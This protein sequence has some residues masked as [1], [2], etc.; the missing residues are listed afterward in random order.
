MIKKLLATTLFFIL[1][2][3]CKD[4]KEVISTDEKSEVVTTFIAEI[5]NE[6]VE[7]LSDSLQLYYQKHDNSPFWN[8]EKNQT[9]L[10]NEIRNCE[11]DGLNP[12]DYHFEKIENYL[13]K[14]KQLSENDLIAFDTILTSAYEKLATHLYSGKI[15]PKAVY[16]DWDLTKRKIGLS[17]SLINS[18]KEENIK[19]SF[20]NLKPKHP[21]YT[22]IKQSLTIL[23]SFPKDDFKKITREEKIELYDTVAEM[24]SIKKRLKYWNDY[25]RNDSVY[26]KIYDSTTYLAIKKFQKRHGLKPDGVIG[27]GTIK[28]LNFSKEERREQ[29]IAN[30]ER[31]KWF[32]RNFGNE[33]LIVNL[34][35]YSLNYIIDSDTVAHHTVVVGKK[36]GELR[37]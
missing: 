35:D 3:S 28:A 34:P 24:I 30:L 14:R 8:I 9:D 23:N 33:Y 20:E 16:S 5:P 18:I 29:I 25:T 17:D 11:A 15:N 2:F 21:T 31:W 12:E 27:K 6:I 19:K 32:P 1:F 7:K 37:F 13:A 36:V 22:S 26:T 10:I 4:K